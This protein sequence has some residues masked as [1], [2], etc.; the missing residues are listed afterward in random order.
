MVGNVRGA[1]LRSRNREKFLARA[2]GV[3]LTSKST[4]AQIMSLARSGRL[5]LFEPE[6]EVGDVSCRRIWLH[7]LVSK[8]VN[9]QGEDARRRRYFDDVRDF[10]RAFVIADDFDSDAVLKPLTTNLGAWYEFKIIFDPHHRIIGGFL[11]P[12]EFVAIAHETR[13]NL[14]RKGFAQTISR[15]SRLWN[16]L[17]LGSRPLTDKR[18]SLLEDFHHDED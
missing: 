5:V 2:G 6:L 4:E 16:S 14:D 12:G 18:S 17:A 7:P 13:K 1:G 3:Q 15:A 9:S 11:R 8:W 10:L